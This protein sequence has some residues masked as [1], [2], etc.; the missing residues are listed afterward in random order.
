M[1]F[2]WLGSAFDDWMGVWGG[3][4]LGAIVCWIG[5]AMVQW[6]WGDVVDGWGMSVWGG[7]CSRLQSDVG[8]SVT[9][10][11]AGRGRT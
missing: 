8:G 2:C 1:S 10:W 11:L 5:W 7:W 3:E 4:P 9:R 6:R